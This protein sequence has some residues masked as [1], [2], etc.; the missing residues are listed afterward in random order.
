MNG[1][2]S[3]DIKPREEIMFI[4]CDAIGSSLVKV[5]RGL[6]DAQHSPQYLFKASRAGAEHA[7]LTCIYKCYTERC[8][9]TNQ[10]HLRYIYEII[11]CDNLHHEL[12]AF[13]AVPLYLV[14]LMITRSKEH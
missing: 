4:E 10:T 2:V 5:Q 11:L 6:K 14:W 3:P 7:H 8:S 1:T 13:D 9:R 12:G